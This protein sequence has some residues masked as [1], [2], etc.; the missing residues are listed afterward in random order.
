MLL[1]FA[2]KK[3]T[4]APDN[5]RYDDNIYEERPENNKRE[6]ILKGFHTVFP[7]TIAEKERDGCPHDERIDFFIHERKKKRDKYVRNF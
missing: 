7:D 2:S 3:A 5:E 1:F 4:N 6:R